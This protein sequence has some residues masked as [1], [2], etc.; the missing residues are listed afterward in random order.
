MKSKEMVV[1]KRCYLLFLFTF[2]FVLVAKVT[3][4]EEIGRRQVMKAKGDSV[5]E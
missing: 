2:F 1:V 5:N 4:V 3:R